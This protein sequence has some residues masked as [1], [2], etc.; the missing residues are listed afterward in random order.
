[1]HQAGYVFQKEGGVHQI[2]NLLGKCPAIILM[3]L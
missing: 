1:M 3:L 2:F